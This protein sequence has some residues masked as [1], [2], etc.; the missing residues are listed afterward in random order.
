MCCLAIALPVVSGITVARIK[1]KMAWVFLKRAQQCLS[2]EGNDME[3]TCSAFLRFCG[4]N[5]NI[6]WLH[7]TFGIEKIIELMD[8]FYALPFKLL[9]NR[10]TKKGF[11]LPFREPRIF[12]N[13]SGS[14]YELFKGMVKRMSLG[15][16]LFLLLSNHGHI[17]LFWKKRG[18][19]YLCIVVTVL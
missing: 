6:K 2:L 8:L 1:R 5:A 9:Y 18:N 12:R 11:L 4:S 10:V 13:N 14:H 16:I 3:W 7:D 15:W 17:F 19:K